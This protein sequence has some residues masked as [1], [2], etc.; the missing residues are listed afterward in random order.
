MNKKLTGLILVVVTLACNLETKENDKKTIQVSAD[1]LSK[2]KSIASPVDTGSAEPYLFTDKN[3]LVYLSWIEKKGKE[4]YFKFS[5]LENDKWSQPVIISSG[6]NW[7]VNWADYPM[8][9]ADGPNNLMAHFLAKSS[10]GKYAYDVKF[11]NSDNSG[12]S[13][14]PAKTLHDDG[15]QAEHG[16]VSMLPYNNDFF[17]SW[18]D[19]RNTGMEEGKGGHEGHHGQMSV[20]GAIIDKQGNKKDEWELDNRVCDCCQ[21][22]ATITTNGPVVVYRDRSDNEIRD[23]SIVRYVNGNWTTP[24]IIFPDD[25]RIEGCPVNGPRADAIGNN[26]AIAWFSMNDKK[27]EV[28]VIFSSDGGATFGKPVQIDEGNTIGRVD[29]VMLDEK[30]AMVSWMEG[31]SIKAIK[32]HSD[33]KKESSIMIAA[34]SESRSSGFPQMTKSGNDLIFAWTDD[35][36]RSIKVAK[37]NITSKEL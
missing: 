36:A 3:G 34:S 14:S 2:I 9:A 37:L 8:L 27:G 31:S 17:I 21:T 25:W 30:T 33:G 15:K 29:L 20:R 22:T 5:M 16:F 7:F 13:W 10:D 1:K 11:L 32:V 18:L 26:L 23:M 19:G 12:K 4:N 28:K 35:K 6:N 24:Q